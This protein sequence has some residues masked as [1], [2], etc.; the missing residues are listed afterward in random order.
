LY[1]NNNKA[2]HKK[3]KIKVSWTI[4]TCT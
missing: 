4:K 2:L 3:K 1:C